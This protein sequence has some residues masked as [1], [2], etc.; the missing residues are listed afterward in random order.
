MGS[1]I[2]TPR[3]VSEVMLRCGCIQHYRRDDDGEVF[4]RVKCRAVE[5]PRCIW[6]SRPI[7]TP[8]RLTPRVIARCRAVLHP[9]AAAALARTG[10]FPPPPAAS[11]LP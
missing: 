6:W 7:T 9:P 11:I 1:S 2:L 10:A 5:D 3:P 8:A 4:L